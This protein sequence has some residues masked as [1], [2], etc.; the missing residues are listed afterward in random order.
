MTGLAVGLTLLVLT[1]LLYYL[2]VATLAAVIIIAVIGLIKIEPIIHAWHAEPHDGIVAVITFILTL[3]F[4]PHLEKGIM[5]GVMLSLVLFVMRTMRPRIAELARYPDGGMRDVAI[6]EELKVSPKIAVVRF[7]MSLYFANAGYFESRMLEIVA[8]RPELKY[9]II[10]AEGING[11]DATGEKA[12]F[13]LWERLQAQGVEIVI[14]RMKRQ[15][16]SVVR[17]TRLFDTMGADHFFSRIGIAL[18]WVY[19]QLGEE[20]DRKNCPLAPIKVSKQTRPKLL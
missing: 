8:S 4:A 2:P 12:L 14:A 1:P 19:S 9:I 10:D 5:I 3:V 7:D 17:R 11:M 16:M 18:E 13:N 6:H 15:F 20:Y